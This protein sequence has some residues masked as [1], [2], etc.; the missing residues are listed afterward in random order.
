MTATPAFTPIDREALAQKRGNERFVRSEMEA[1]MIREGY[2][3]AEQTAK[4][5]FVGIYANRKLRAELVSALRW[6]V[7]PY[8]KRTEAGR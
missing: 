4:H 2:T 3:F 5:R 1:K 6:P 7:L 8:P